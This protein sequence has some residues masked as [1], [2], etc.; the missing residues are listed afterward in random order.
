MFDM[1]EQT[2]LWEISLIKYGKSKKTR[3][4]KHCHKDFNNKE[5]SKKMHDIFHEYF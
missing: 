5:Y 4:S 3:I 2:H 1:D